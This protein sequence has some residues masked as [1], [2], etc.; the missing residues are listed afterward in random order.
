MCIPNCVPP[1]RPLRARLSMFCPMVPSWLFTSAEISAI[2][3]AGSS[4][5]LVLPASFARRATRPSS[6][7]IACPTRELAAPK[8]VLCGLGLE[9][10]GRPRSWQRASATA[11]NSAVRS[12]ACGMLLL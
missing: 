12:S 1:G 10:G 3:T 9:H 2:S 5:R 8:F 4:K 6:S 11:K 7:W